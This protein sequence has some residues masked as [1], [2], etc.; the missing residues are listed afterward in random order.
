MGEESGRREEHS[1]SIG[2][3]RNIKMKKYKGVYHK[4]TQQWKVRGGRVAAGKKGKRWHEEKDRRECGKAGE[5][6]EMEE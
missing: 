2:K 5:K 4:I 1:N 6:H 3:T